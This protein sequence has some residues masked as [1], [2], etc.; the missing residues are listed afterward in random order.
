[1]SEIT[2][3]HI[4]RLAEVN[5]ST[6]SR[7]LRNH[8][9]IPPHTCRRIQRLADKLGYRPNPLVSA[10][11]QLRRAAHPL[12]QHNAIAYLTAFASRSGWRGQPPNFFPGAQRRCQELGYE[13]ADFWLN[14]PGMSPRRL[15]DILLARNIRGIV[16]ARTP[17]S[18][19]RL[20]FPWEHFATVSLGVMLDHPPTHH[21]AHHHFDDA[22]AALAHCQARG[23]RRVGLVLMHYHFRR[24][25]QR[26]LGASETCA[27]DL[28]ATE[29]IEPYLHNEAAPQKLAAWVRR[30]RV[31]AIMTGEVEAA[32]RALLAAGLRVPQDVGL[33]ALNLFTA[34]P[35]LAGMYHDPVRTGSVAVD[36]LTAQL[37]RNE[38]G[39]PA[40]PTEVLLKGHWHDGQSLPWRVK[41]A[42]RLSPATGRLSR[43]P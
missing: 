27:R 17:P 3:A 41:S 31:Q 8:P 1:M 26:W 23:Y 19:T 36:L 21:V 9:R 18:I 22:A 5:L 39:L 28:P 13:L 35:S 20:D 33:A 32:R 24:A 4:A 14:E 15:A 7:A 10:L 11:M 25:Q 29:R 38:I 42:D 6:V 16:I 40:D 12:P 30:N 43:S 2:L 37:Y 34:D